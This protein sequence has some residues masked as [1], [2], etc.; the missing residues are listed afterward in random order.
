EVGPHDVAEQTEHAVEV[1]PMRLD[2]AVRQQVQP[3]V[4]VVRV[5]R[6]LVQ[7]ADGGAHSDDL[8]ASVGV[9]TQQ[10]CDR[11]AQ[12]ALCLLGRQALRS[13]LLGRVHQ[14]RL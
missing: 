1:L 4:D 11:R 8:D 2:Q 14:L 7:F 13:G 6:W 9:R 3:Q 12:R 5:G 10:A